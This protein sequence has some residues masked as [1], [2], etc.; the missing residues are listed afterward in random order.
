MT[1]DEKIIRQVFQDY[2]TAYFVERNFEKTKLL[3]SNNITVVGTGSDEYTTN[4]ADVI[5]LYKRDFEQAPNKCEISEIDLTVDIISDT[6]ALVIS[7]FKLRTIIDEEVLLID[8]LRMSFYYEKQN[9]TWLI[10]HKHTS[11]PYVGQSSSMSYPIEDVEKRYRAFMDSSS[12]AFYLSDI[13]GR[14]IDVNE[15]AC[16]GFGYTREELLSLSIKDIDVNFSADNFFESRKSIIDSKFNI[17]ETLHRQKNGKTFPVEVKVSSTLINEEQLF[18]SLARDITERKKNEKLQKALFRISEE[19]SKT[20]TLDELY[21]SLHGIIAT[22]MP[23]KNFY[24]AIH[25]SETDLV[26]FPYYFD[27]Y[28]P[29]PKERNYSTGL[30]EYVLERKES[31]IFNDENIIRKKGIIKVKGIFPKAWIGIYLE[32]EGKYKGVLTLQDYENENAYSEEDIKVLQFVSEQIVKVLD[33]RY[34]DANLRKMVK[35]LFE[36]KEELE[37]INK[38]KDRFFSIISHDLKSPFSSIL[39]ATEMLVSDY[40]E[41]TSYEIKDM[42][43]MLRNSSVNVYNLLEDLLEWARTQTDRMEYEF[44]N[45]DFYETSI[46]IINLLKT[47]ASNK[48]IFIENGVKENTLIFADEKA[49]ETVL[50]NLIANAIKF[51]KPDGIIKIETEM[52]DGEIAISVSD[53][54]IGMSEADKNKLFK[55]ELHH[56]TV[57]T[58]KEAGTGVG[59][60]LCKELVEKHGGKIW[61]ESELGIGSKFVFALPKK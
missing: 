24:I 41:L 37:L 38:N 2:L 12:D 15:S 27:E 56:T 8:N 48:N 31:Q 51:T 43:N 5:T 9:N 29:S 33:K 40:D 39:G 57:G 59:L 50:R 25:N 16:I 6:S 42:I 4:S 45:I 34:A 44:K 55:I 23:V 58:N 36:A 61:V 26:K 32:F 17:F 35:K 10:R 3:L 21:K 47:A 13:K 11:I 1:K 14:F 54:G 28:D 30:T 60:I 52:R 20:T 22:L 18:V 46:K 7:Y 53:S 19:A 49:T